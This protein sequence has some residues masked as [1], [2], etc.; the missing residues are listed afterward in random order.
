MNADTPA[1]VWF[2]RSFELGL[3]AVALPDIVERLR[4]TPWRLEERMRAVGASATSRPADSPQTPWSAQE[5]AGHLVDLEHLWLGRLDDLAAGRERLRDADLENRA[6]W[7]ADHNAR[8]AEDILADFRGLRAEL[9]ARVEAM[10]EAESVATALH[11]RLEQPMSVVDLCFFVAEHDDH[12]LAAITSRVISANDADAVDARRVA[13]LAQIF[14]EAGAAH[15]QAFLDTDGA[16]PDWP[17]WY[18]HHLFPTLAPI[19]DDVTESEIVGWL[20]AWERTH[21][22]IAPDRPW[23]EFYAQRLARLEAASTKGAP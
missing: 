13:D 14:R 18:A 3:P 8:R 19:L 16:D 22:A 10:S 2:E 7:D 23:P 1:R 5:H 20:L 4:G 12:H 6:T 11:P 21:H 9:V 17:I 15:H